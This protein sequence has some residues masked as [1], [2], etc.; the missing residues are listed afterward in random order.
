MPC[1]RKNQCKT[2]GGADRF[3]SQCSTTTGKPK[4]DKKLKEKRKVRYTQRG[5][6]DEDAEY[7]FTIKSVW[8]DVL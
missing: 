7:A 4:T 3:T 6:D 5:D 2:C 1:E 8:V